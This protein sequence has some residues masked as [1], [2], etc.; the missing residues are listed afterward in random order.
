MRVTLEVDPFQKRPNADLVIRD[1]DGEDVA[2]TS[3][4][5]SLERHMEAT[6]HLR[7]GRQS[8]RFSVHATLY[9]VTIEEPGAETTDAN[10]GIEPIQRQVVDRA[11]ADFELPL[12]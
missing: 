12:S 8:G 10:P 3:I 7:G 11:Q 5:E 9:Y 4:V 6:M 1:E 2:H